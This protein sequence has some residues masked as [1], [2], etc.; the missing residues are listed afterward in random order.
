MIAN[1]LK[2]HRKKLINTNV[3]LGKDA[4]YLVTSRGRNKQSKIGKTK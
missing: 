3:I 4:L 1:C 2:S